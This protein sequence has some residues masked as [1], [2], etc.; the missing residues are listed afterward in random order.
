PDGSGL[1]TEVASAEAARAAGPLCEGK[2]AAQAAPSPSAP[3]RRIWTLT[4]GA[5][6]L[7]TLTSGIWLGLSAH[8][9][10][11]PLHQPYP[12]GVITN[13]ADLDERD[14]A[15]TR[16][17]AANILVDVGIA[18]AVG[19]A[20]LYWFEGRTPSANSNRAQTITPVLSSNFGGITWQGAF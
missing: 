9:T 13:P 20:V 18:A 4:T 11:D 15:R 6:A 7:A 8:S 12:S 16:Q 10:F 3:P 2:L 1:E 14:G 5:V 19:T 17:T